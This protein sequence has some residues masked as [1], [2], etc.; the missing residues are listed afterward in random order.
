[1]IQRCCCSLVAKQGL[2]QA[3]RARACHTLKWLKRITGGVS[4]RSVSAIEAITLVFDVQTNS[5][6]KYVS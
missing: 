5:I 6:Y 1:M 3:Q 2:M 4:L